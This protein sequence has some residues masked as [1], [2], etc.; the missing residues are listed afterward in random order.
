MTKPLGLL[1]NVLQPPTASGTTIV[2][3][4]TALNGLPPASQAD[5]GGRPPW[6]VIS[7]RTLVAAL[8]IDRGNWATW[9]CR[10]IGPAELPAS[11]FRP[12]PGRP[13]YYQIDTVLAWIAS[14][15]GEQYETL[16]LW[17]DWF[18]INCE[19]DIADPDELR[20][21]AQL[22]ARATGPVVGDIRFSQAG[23]R[24]YIDSLDLDRNPVRA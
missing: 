5:F 17:R 14:R 23:F 21:Q 7:T 19:T 15:R 24:A 13:R 11:W 1:K 12:A 4:A 3:P 9:R 2:K 10:G 16:S 6:S 22:M 8:G 18:R 20:R